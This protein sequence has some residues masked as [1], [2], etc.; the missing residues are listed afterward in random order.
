MCCTT[1]LEAD[2][3]SLHVADRKLFSSWQCGRR[4][5]G[6]DGPSRTINREEFKLEGSERRRGVKNNKK[7]FRTRRHLHAQSAH[8]LLLFTST[9]V[10]QVSS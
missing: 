9:A 3:R 6:G 10:L 7:A 4:G 1:E 2:L 5:V 8:Q